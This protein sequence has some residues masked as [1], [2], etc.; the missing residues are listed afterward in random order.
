M[1]ASM[2]APLKQFVITENS[3]AYWRIT[4][5][6]PPLNLI[7]PET[8]RELK[9]LLELIEAQND[10]RVVFF[11]SANPDFYFARYDLSRAAETLT[12]PR[13]TGFPPWIDFVLHIAHSRVI[14]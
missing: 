9:L 7:N 2:S 1:E 12:E 5:G 11:D 10:L 14:R 4:F 3:K 13:P 8:V 6:N